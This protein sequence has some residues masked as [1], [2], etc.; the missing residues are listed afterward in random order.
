[1]IFIFSFVVLMWMGR[2]PGAW[3]ISASGKDCTALPQK[4]KRSNNFKTLHPY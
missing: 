1:M 4:E 2:L 3:R